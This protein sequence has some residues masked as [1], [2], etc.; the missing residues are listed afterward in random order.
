MDLIIN[1]EAIEQVNEFKYL[2]L[3]LDST[4]TFTPHLNKLYKTACQQ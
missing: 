1:N 3:I 4:L 2:G